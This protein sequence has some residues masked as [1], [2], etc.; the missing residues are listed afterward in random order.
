MARRLFCLRNVVGYAGALAL[1][2][3]AGRALRTETPGPV[4]GP[5]E[6]APA[7]PE[8]RPATPEERPA[9]KPPE[10]QALRAAVD[11]LPLAELL[12]LAIR[13][14]GWDDEG[15]RRRHAHERL[16]ERAAEHAAECTPL[17]PRLFD[18][19]E[20][21]DARAQEV[22]V[23][24]LLTL[25]RVDEAYVPRM[26]ALVRGAAPYAVRKAMVP[27][28]QQLGPRAAAA[29]PALE[30]WRRQLVAE[31]SVAGAPRP[32]RR[33]PPRLADVVWDDLDIQLAYALAAITGRLPGGP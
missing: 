31:R 2:F 9:A 27:L 14:P 25:G 21:G 12:E 6:R 18:L 22:A 16:I 33:R 7:T 5:V 32:G 29:A 23:D 20:R 13:T 11:R 1:G 19:L 3:L 24:V 26:T 10:A 28:L 4:A 8:E 30:A 17:V 15:L